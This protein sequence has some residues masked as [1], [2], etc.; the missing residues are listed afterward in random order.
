[1]SK[2][3]LLPFILPA[4]VVA[5]SLCTGIF[6]MYANATTRELGEGITMIEDIP[7]VPGSADGRQLLDLYLP[8]NK[9]KKPLPTVIWI[10]GGAWLIG[11]KKDMPA[12]RLVRN[13]FAVASINYRL[14][15]TATFPAQLSDCKAAVRYLRANAIRYKLDPNRMG[16]WGNSA[17]GH[18]A[19]LLGTTG[20]LKDMDGNLGVA[21]QSTRLQA[22]CDWCGPTD[23]MTIK[24]QSGK[25]C[26]LDHTSDDS[27]VKL[28]LGGFP[29]EKP[30]L[31]KKA[32][33]VNFA[34]KDDPPFLIMHGDL[35]D[36]VPIAQSEELCKSLKAAGVSTTYYVV[37]SAGHN[38]FSPK[39]VQMVQDFF[40]Q[41]L[42]KGA[43]R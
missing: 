29:S 6:L 28:L 5:A 43:T 41:Y 3:R 22:V 37:P 27:P 25:F 13:G 39:N 11:S 32:S 12:L 2:G 30:E 17:G 16:V 26:R 10:H 18:L 24:A 31:A 40:Q 23:L 42:M 19:A 14:S 38:F 36:V 35:D 8:E 15:K 9:A 7:Y 1:M 20:D 33:P 34:S 21:A 4:A